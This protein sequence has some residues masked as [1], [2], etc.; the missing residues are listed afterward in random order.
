MDTL[1][2]L[3]FLLLF[4]S[5]IVIS[6]KDEPN[7]VEE[8]PQLTQDINNFIKSVMEEVYLWYK[9]LPDIDTRYE[10]DSKEY[11]EK[12][13][14][15]DD[16][17][18]FV[19]DDVESY[20]NSI[21]GVEKSYGWSLAFGNFVD[22]NSNPTG[23]MFALV[24]F[25][26]PGSPADLA[27]IKRGDFIY[28]INDADITEVNYANLL[29]TSSISFEYGQVVESNIL[30]SKSASLTALELNLNPVVFTNII[31]EGGKK[32]GYLFYAQFIDKYNSSIDTALQHFVD[33][34]VTDLVL[35]L[36]YNPGGTSPATQHLCSA[37][38]PPDAVNNNKVIVS[39]L[40][41]NKFQDYF[42]TNGIMN[43][44]EIRFTNAIDIKLGLNSVHVLTGRGTASASELLITG[45]DAYMN[46]VKV[47][48]TT[49]G[50]YT[51][52]AISWKPEDFYEDSNYYADFKNWGIYAIMFRFANSVGVTDFKNG[53]APNI[54][55]EDDIFSPT[56]LGDKTEAL[57]KAA[58]EDITGIEVLAKKSTSIPK[59]EIFDRGFSKFDAFKREFLITDFDKDLAKR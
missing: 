57:L 19:T 58:I 46:V 48:E 39:Y 7:P 23:D 17:W 28:K 9:E 30:N 29:N 16:K 25:V 18:S 26:Y 56:P 55:V 51:G 1:K 31:E 53:F 52:G 49:Y 13:R 42:E 6:C 45:L 4:T 12:L 14:Y 43:Q 32:I 47:G 22:E 37:I 21:E 11:F 15:T 41:N 59:Y 24:E 34:G 10:F 40:W 33:A 50:K 27:G 36:R 44:L 3:L 8:A 38:A 54:E 35:D 5:G 2:K 20:E